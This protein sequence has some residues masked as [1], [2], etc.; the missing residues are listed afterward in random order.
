AF[1]FEAADF[2]PLLKEII[3]QESN[4]WLKYHALKAYLK[5]AVNDE[6]YQN[7]IKKIKAK[8]KEPVLLALR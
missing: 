7:F 1:G 4:P 2:S 5:I 3:N 6:D 8:E